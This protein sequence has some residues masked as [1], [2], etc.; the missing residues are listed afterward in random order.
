MTLNLSETICHRV[1][2]DGRRDCDVAVVYWVEETRASLCGVVDCHLSVRSGSDSVEETEHVAVF[3]SADFSLCQVKGTS[4][5]VKTALLN[6]GNRN[7]RVGHD[8]KR[9]NGD[10]LGLGNPNDVSAF[11]ANDEGFDEGAP[12]RADHG[13]ADTSNSL[14]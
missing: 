2:V 14:S 1:D 12:R 5:E 11:L 13:L 9:R 3:G 7:H 4:D 6:L 10:T 8:F